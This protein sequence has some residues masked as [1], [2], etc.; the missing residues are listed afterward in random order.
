MIQTECGS[1]FLRKSVSYY[2]LSMLIESI[3]TRCGQGVVIGQE[4]VLVGLKLSN[5][6][7]AWGECVADP[8]TAVSFTA[9]YGIET[10][11]EKIAPR[12]IGKPVTHLSEL[13]S[14][15]TDLTEEITI[16]ETTYPPPPMQKTP[17]RRDILR[18]DW[19]PMTAVPEPIIHSHQIERP[20]HAA[21]RYGISQ[22]LLKAVA[23]TQEKS[24]VALVCDMAGIDLPETAVSLQSEI[25]PQIPLNIST[26][27]KN[28]VAS[29]GYTTSGKNHE[30]ELGKQGEILQRFARQLATQLKKTAAPE[31]VAF[32]FRVR[33]GYGALCNNNLGKVLGLL[34]GLETAAKPF[35][36]RVEDPILY[37]ERDEQIKEIANLK[38]YL[39]MRKL[40]LELVAH[41]HVDTLADVKA[42]VAQKAVPMMHIDLGQMGNLDE[43]IT[44]VHHCHQH[45]VKTFIGG[46][47]DETPSAAKLTAQISLALQ[48][49]LA[50]A[51]PGR[52]GEAGLATYYNQMQQDV[53][54][55]S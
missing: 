8:N 19:Q 25:N 26:I 1:N 37:R 7:F 2:N 47:P 42:F 46:T 34:Y 36:V 41:T 40:N 16:T 39:L 55:F 17:S 48:P 43:A 52:L 11:E 22:A 28:S 23:I 45:N 49:T 4:I 53:A 14:H 5:G 31:Q 35:L 6:R 20:I 9:Q 30:I 51:K 27:V 38:S 44:A 3:V 13:M 32:Y 15:I 24:I 21:I 12:L 50:L 29:V 10:I 54:T 18:G 33:G